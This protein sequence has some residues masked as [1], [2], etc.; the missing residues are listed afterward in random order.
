MELGLI[1]LEVS[2][3]LMVIF[4]LLGK[5]EVSGRL[6]Q[7]VGSEDRRPIP[8]RTL[9]RSIRPERKQLAPLPLHH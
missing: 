8:F 9:K 6:G 3:S 7:E 2:R 5:K 4:K 1:Y